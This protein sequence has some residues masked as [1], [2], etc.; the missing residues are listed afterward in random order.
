MGTRIELPAGQWADL[1]HPEAIPRRLARQYRNAYYA[2]GAAA[3][4]N[5][6]AVLSAAALEQIEALGD[7]LVLTIVEDWSYGAVTQEVLDEVSDTS[8]R[9]LQDAI[10]EG[11]YLQAL[12]PDFSPT[13]DDASPTGPSGA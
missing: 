9:A 7:V 12:M 4:A 6:K 1:R 11:G 3:S 8:L 2:L 10:G 5:G 13:P